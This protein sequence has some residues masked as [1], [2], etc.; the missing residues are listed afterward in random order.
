MR[1]KASLHHHRVFNHRIVT[2]LHRH[3]V[4]LRT[5]WSFSAVMVACCLFCRLRPIILRNQLALPDCLTRALI[6]ANKT[7][8]AALAAGYR[9]FIVTK[10]NQG[11]ATAAFIVVDDIWLLPAED[12]VP[13]GRSSLTTR[14][15]QRTR[16]DR[17][18]VVN[19][20]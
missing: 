3:R 7:T 11:L 20:R 9:S 1:K 17:G 12:S 5:R 19:A 4:W 14:G 15:R 13:S 10:W 16:R 6:T 8:S 18:V 2:S